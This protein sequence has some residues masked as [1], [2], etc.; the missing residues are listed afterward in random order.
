MFFFHQLIP[1]WLAHTPDR[2]RRFA[3]KKPSV[4]REILTSDGVKVKLEVYDPVNTAGNT[5]SDPT[6]EPPILFLPGITGVNP[7][8]SI[9]ALPFQSCNMVEYFT[10]HGYRCYILTPKWSYD[11]RIAKNCTVF[12]SR[13]DI[14]AALHHISTH[15]PL[16][17]Q[18]PYIIAP[19]QD[20]LHS[21]W[22][23]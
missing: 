5:P 8:H 15:E 13:L 2:G 3:A 22:P 11:E 23:Y 16:Q 20:L 12:D 10:S 21:Q 19:C 7:E 9:F 17:S 1:R 18:R 4:T 14:A 6:R